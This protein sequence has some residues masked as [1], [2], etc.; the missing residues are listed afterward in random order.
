MMAGLMVH[1]DVNRVKRA[2]AR[3]ARGN[4]WLLTWS[5][6]MIHPVNNQ[7]ENYYVTV[8]RRLL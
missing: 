5:G 3:I 1:P 4:Q 8:L 6:A 7:F 2:A